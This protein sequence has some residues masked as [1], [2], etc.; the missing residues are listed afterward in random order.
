M[1]DDTD[2][3]P[4][5]ELELAPKRVAELAASGEAMLIDVRQ[6]Y[7]WEAGRI[8]GA[9][10]VEVNR[11]TAEAASIPKDRPV[12]F[13]CRGGSRS[14]MA[15]QAFREAGWDAHNIAAGITAWVGAGLE[16]EPEDGTVA[17]ARPPSA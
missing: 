14:G 8:A 7:E 13:Y 3:P 4:Q 9:R 5:A 15:A 10:H 1:A 16:L 2:S 17:A 11:L 6:D 12:V